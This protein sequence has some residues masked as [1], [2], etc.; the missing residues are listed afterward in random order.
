MIGEMQKTI[1]TVKGLDSAKSYDSKNIK[2]HLP[3]FVES[4]NAKRENPNYEAGIKTKYSFIDYATNGLRPADFVI[5]AGESGFG[6]SL[7]LNT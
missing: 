6:K 2:D 7:L 1:Q 4:F 5:I 3:L